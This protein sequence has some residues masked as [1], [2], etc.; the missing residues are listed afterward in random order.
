MVDDNTHKKQT[1]FRR[2]VQTVLTRFTKPSK[3]TFQTVPLPLEPADNFATTTASVFWSADQND[4]DEGLFGCRSHQVPVGGDVSHFTTL[5][6][7]YKVFQE[8]IIFIIYIYFLSK[9]VTSSTW[10]VYFNYIQLQ[11]NATKQYFLLTLI[12]HFFVHLAF[13]AFLCC[14]FYLGLTTYYNALWDAF[15]L[16]ETTSLTRLLHVWSF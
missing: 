3:R 11:H 10:H 4:P 2:Y 9:S 15:V 7:K 1:T 6:N 13:C 8:T 5:L 14:M 12:Y 16:N